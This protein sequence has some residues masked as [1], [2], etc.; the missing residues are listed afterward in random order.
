MAASV[1]SH[2]AIT[3]LDE[4]QHL[5]DPSVRVQRPTVGERYDRTF[6]PVL[7]VNLRAIFCGN[8]GS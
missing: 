8:G 5:T 6:S 3:V 4:K 2:T 1:N 7:V